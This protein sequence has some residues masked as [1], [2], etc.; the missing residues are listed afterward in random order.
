MVTE[1]ARLKF[2][3]KKGLKKGKIEEYYTGPDERFKHTA[4]EGGPKVIVRY[5]GE[6]ATEDVRKY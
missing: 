6:R 5:G 3:S 2:V 1:G 4:D